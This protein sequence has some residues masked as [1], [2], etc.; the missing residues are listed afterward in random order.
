M[1]RTPPVRVQL[2]PQPAVQA[3]VALTSTLAAGG[4]AAWAF[5]HHPT[6]WLL[7]LGVPVTAAWA[8]R[9]AAVLPRLLRWD[10][11]SWWLTEPGASAETTVSLAVLID[12]DGWLLLR[13]TP[14]PR[15]LPLSRRQQAAHWTALRATLF[16]APSG[17]TPR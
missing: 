4:L 11:Q 9:A 6:G 3:V 1:R 15:W 8:W 16:A 2:E 10:G 5:S 12:L 17:A 14:G 13:A 7:W